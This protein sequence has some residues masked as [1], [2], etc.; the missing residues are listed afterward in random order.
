MNGLQQCTDRIFFTC[1]QFLQIQAHH[2]KPVLPTLSIGAN[3][4]AASAQLV[5]MKM[6][7]LWLVVHCCSGLLHAGLSVYDRG[8][9]FELT[10]AATILVWFVQS[11]ATPP[12]LQH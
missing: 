9:D 1:W 2:A 5:L 8:G 7:S 12:L 10:V 11:F 3:A 6:S 4:T